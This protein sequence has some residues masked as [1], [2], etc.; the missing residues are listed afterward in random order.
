MALMHNPPHPGLVLREYLGAIEPA[1]AARRLGVSS[2]A[3][4]RVLNGDAPISADLSVRL[5]EAL[6]THA[7]FWVGLQTD[8]DLWH[9]SQA[10]R[11]K[12]EP[13]ERVA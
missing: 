3:I 6:G 8:Y 2:D 5:A 10:V 9:A 13:F 7:G 11:P 4:L 1:E 12:I